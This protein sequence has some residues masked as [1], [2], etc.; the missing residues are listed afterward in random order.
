MFNFSNRSKKNIKNIKNIKKTNAHKESNHNTTLITS[1]EGIN[2]YGKIIKVLGS[3]NFT[4][5]CSDGKERIGKICGKMRLK[6]WIGANDIVLISLRSFQDNK[7]D[8][9]HKYSD[10]D[11]RLLNKSNE[12][13][14]CNT[15]VKITN[16]VKD[17]V[18]DCVFNFEDI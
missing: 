17:G 13:S 9:I 3:G 2:C 15:A 16:E 6:V 7:A 8:I 14:F 10:G 18:D 4:V 1:I 12:L 11:V 5:I